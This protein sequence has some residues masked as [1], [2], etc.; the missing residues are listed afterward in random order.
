[1]TRLPPVEVLLGPRVLL[2]PHREDDAAV[3]FQAV[4]NDRKRLGRFLPWVATVITIEDELKFIQDMQWAWQELTQF[5]FGIYDAVSGAYMGNIGVHNISWEHR[6]CELGYWLLSH[7]EGHGW[8]SESVR[9]LE[10]E[11]FGLGFNKIEIRC[12]TANV[13]SRRVPE[14]LGYHLDGILREDRLHDGHFVDNYVFSRLKS[15]PIT[16]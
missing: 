12:D 15:D 11:F 5:D 7:Y 1:M 16:G 6:H 2:R 8:V 4:E 14:R 13:L 10:S 9:V 3:M